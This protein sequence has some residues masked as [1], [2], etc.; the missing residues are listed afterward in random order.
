M[1][2]YTCCHNGDLEG[3]RML[4]DQNCDINHQADSG[5]TPLRLALEHRHLHI[6]RELIKHGVNVNEQINDGSTCLHIA[7][8]HGDIEVVRELL[9]YC[10]HLINDNQGRTALDVAQFNE[11]RQLIQSY[12]EPPDIKEPENF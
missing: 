4:I 9:G 7:S 3:F 2:I 10:D 11:I 8:S 5:F 12:V 1:D 6:V